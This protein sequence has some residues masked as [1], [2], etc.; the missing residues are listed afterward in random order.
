MYKRTPETD[1]WI[2][3]LWQ[4]AGIWPWSLVEAAARVRLLQ[5][6]GR[7]GN[8]SAIPDIFPLVLLDNVK[9]ATAAVAAVQQLLAQAHPEELPCLDVAL[10]S[11]TSYHPSYRPWYQLTPAQVDGF[12]AYGAAAVPLLGVVACHRDGYVRER[13]VAALAHLSDIRA[14]PYLLLRTTDWVPQVRAAAQHGVQVWLTPAHVDAFITN[15]PLVERLRNSAHAD[16]GG[17]IAG[18]FTVLQA[19]EARAYLHDGFTA[20][21]R[22]LRRRCFTLALDAPGED[23]AAIIDLAYGSHD[24]V[25]QLAAVQR[26]AEVL[27]SEQLKGLLVRWARY[28]YS[29]VRKVVFQVAAEC[30]PELATQ[31]DNI[32]VFDTN[33]GIRAFARRQFATM[34]YLAFYRTALGARPRDVSLAVIYGLGETGD[35]SDAILLL[36]FAIEGREHVRQ[37]A[38]RAILRLDATGHLDL[39]KDALVDPQTVISKVGYEALK[40][41]VQEAGVPWLATLLRTH[42]LVH[43]RRHALRLL[44]CLGKWERLPYLL[45]GLGDT[46]A[47]VARTSRELF[48]AWMWRVNRSFIPPTTA[49]RAQIDAALAACR[50]GMT[51][52]ER[53]QL[54][55]MLNT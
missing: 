12:A 25:I 15:W 40:D 42:P 5:A 27:P 19:P 4:P 30:F 23:V 7:A 29:K 26:A 11:R 32:A 17:L 2:W 6:I 49:Q 10:R 45:E 1:E 18:L 39:F 36:P 16:E 28:S 51:D 14:L 38:L 24:T 8:L 22:Q 54:H 55:F 31:M 20:P 37:A 44:A 33:P 50:T 41:R 52:E 34:D 43:V 46:D 13:A 35:A 21:N 9:V 3:Q 48:N 53:R 47:G